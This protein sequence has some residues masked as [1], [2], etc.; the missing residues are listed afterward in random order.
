MIAPPIT[1]AV[2]RPGNLSRPQPVK[3]EKLAVI[4]CDIHNAMPN[5]ATLLKYLPSRWHRHYETIG[6]R[7]HIGSFYPRAMKNAARHDSWPPSGLPPGGDV[8]FLQKQLLDQWDLEFGI[9]NCLYGV[10]GELNLEF[11]AALAQAVNDWQIAE[12]LEPEPRLRA[13]IIVP[14]EDGELSAAEI[15]RVA[16]HPGYVQV[17]LIARTNAP[18]GHRKYWKLYEAAV[19]HDLPIGI[20]FGGAGGGPITGAGWPSHYIEDHGGMPQAFYAQV[21]SMVTSGIF[22]RFPT[23]KIVLIEG[24]FAWLPPLMWRLD[25]TW[26]QLKEEA[27]T[28]TRLPSE[29]IREHFWVTT[30]PMEEPPQRRYFLQL[31]EQ[32]DMNDRLMFATD[33]PH[34]DF[35]APDQCFPVELPTPLKRDI[36]AEN[37][38]KLY[39]F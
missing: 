20:H 16:T 1:P 12:W 19:R 3:R 22:E 14:Y 29:I 32:M 30:Q 26:K 10:G 31:L 28:L 8:P 15:E 25:A 27:P 2:I 9:L 18:L 38:R 39:R 7:S 36:L 6:P 11:G 5:D 33:Y 35:D 23:L 37:A 24:G 17:M 4:D 21:I 34:W 13:S